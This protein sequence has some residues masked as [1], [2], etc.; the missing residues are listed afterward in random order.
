M[1]REISSNPPYILA[2]DIGTSHARAL[3]FDRWGNA[4]PSI[5][6]RQLYQFTILLEG[7]I[8]TDAEALLERVLRCIDQALEQAG[9]LAEEIAG[10][11]AC[12][13]VSNIVGIDRS[14]TALTPLFP[15]S[16]TRP[17]ADTRL[18]REQANEELTHQR[19]GCYFHSSYLPARFRWLN[20]TR[21]EIFQKAWRWISLG[22]YLWF[23]LFGEAAVSYSV[24][25]WTGLLNRQHLAWDEELLDL[26]AVKSQ[27]LS[28]LCDID[29]PMQGLRRDFRTRWPA[30]VNI[31]WFPAIGDGA[32]ANIGSGCTSAERVT[33]SLGSTSAVRAVIRDEIAHIPKGLWCYRVDR[34]RA[35]LGGALTEGGNLFNW[36]KRLLKLENIP[37]LEAA[38]LQT[39]P[40]G[41]GLTLLPLVAGERSPGWADD[42]SGAVTGLTLATTPLD[43]LQAGLEGVICRVAQVYELLAQALPSQPQIIASGGAAVHSPFMLSR[44]A[45]ALG[46]P[47]YPSQ[48]E[49]ASAR[50]A[51]LLALEALG[52]I[53]DAGKMLLPAGEAHLPDAERH[54][55]FG[56]L[57]GLQK[58]LYEKIINPGFI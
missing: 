50:G 53:Q 21:P 31:P 57:I 40:G 42:A 7:G 55:H 41:H 1:V 36:L 39:T 44:L 48:V 5:E 20:R 52:M 51:A 30:L 28:P 19:V 27:Q 46:Q 49:E 35:L 13:F 17:A 26:L 8:E 6:G 29:Q 10:V 14:G 18:L 23:K 32:T 4:V 33:I 56:K 43:L 9:S 54:R 58:E 34:Q 47:V 3:L 12:T 11:A 37:D 2:L 24:A 22:E 38:L 15:Y 25:S 45:D 16:D